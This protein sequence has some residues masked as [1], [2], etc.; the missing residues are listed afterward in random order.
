MLG[1][2]NGSDVYVPLKKY[3]SARELHSVRIYQ[4]CGPLHFANVEFFKKDLIRRT[5]VSVNDI[6][7]QRNKTKKRLARMDV[8]GTNVRN[9]KLAEEGA[10][11]PTHIIIDCSMFSYIDTTGVSQLKVTVLEYESIGIKTYLA[12]VAVH[13]DKMLHKDNFYKEV[14]PH[15]VYITIHDAV[16][17]ALE[18]IEDS[19]GDLDIKSVGADSRLNMTTSDTESCACV[20]LTRTSAP[21]AFNCECSKRNTNGHVKVN[22]S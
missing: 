19:Y 8:E 4:F 14:P 9:E 3:A 10:Y 6:I 13:V 7:A 12:G 20:N 21:A 5:G 1:S 17:H 11:Q 16:H 15:H 2:I 18:D 22:G